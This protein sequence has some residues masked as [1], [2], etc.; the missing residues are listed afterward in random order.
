VAAGGSGGSTQT[1]GL[2][3][4]VVPVHNRPRLLVE[5]VESA[6]DQSYPEIELIVVDDASTDETPQ[7][8]AGLVVRGAGRMRALRH[9]DN[10][11]PGASRESGRQA[12]R[13]EYLQ[14]LDSDDLLLAGKLEE[15]VAA[16][17]AEPAAGIVY[18]WT[19]ARHFD[20]ALDERPV[21]RTGERF[22]TLFPALL[23]GRIWITA[24]PLYRAELVESAGGWSSLRLDEDWELEARLAARGA[25][26]AYVE[27]WVAEHRAHGG[28]HAGSVDR[29][30]PTR[31][32]DRAA[33]MRSIFDSA[34]AAGIGADAPEMARFARALF[35]LARR[36]GAAGL[37]GEARSLFVLARRASTPAR[38]R[39]WDFRLVG[40]LA[41][42]LGWRAAGRAA[43]RLDALRAR[44][45]GGASVS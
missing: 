23:A 42:T 14:F 24:T 12:A 30:D 19:R 22:E 43:E 5:A 11:G 34:R 38:A 32:R 21:R 39:R 31:L 27:R 26:L 3:S 2:V 15:Q 25:R 10:R 13:G 9:D 29:R 18:G 36:C 40:A 33:A 37:T 20:G 8:I 41:A 16:L 7:A 28:E 6:L 17:A 35:L 45:R 44:R 4:V 1:P